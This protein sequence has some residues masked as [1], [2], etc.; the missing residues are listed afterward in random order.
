MLGLESM[1]RRGRDRERG[2]VQQGK[3][4]NT[5]EPVL[6]N[7]LQYSFSPG[8]WNV[9]MKSQEETSMEL[10]MGGESVAIHSCPGLIR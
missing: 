7:I 2:L 6:R 1:E 8:I 5:P 9:W 10:G 4:G 3:G